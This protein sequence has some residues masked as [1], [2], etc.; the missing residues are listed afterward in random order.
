MG[1]GTETFL[2]DWFAVANYSLMK[3][4]HAYWWQAWAGFCLLGAMIGMSPLKF[5]HEQNFRQII[6]VVIRKAILYLSFLLLSLPLISLYL[7][8]A[9]TQNQLA[10]SQ[11]TFIKW[12]IALAKDNWLDPVAGLAVGFAFRFTF[13]RYVN[14]YISNLMRKLRNEVVEDKLSD[15]RSEAD[16]YKAKDFDPQKHYKPDQVFV[17]LDAESKPIYIPLSTWLETNAQVIGPTRYGKGVLLGNLIDQSIRRG[18]TVFYLDPKEDKFLPK[19]MQ[20]ACED[21]GRKFYYLTLH[22]D[23]IG[24]WAPF[25]GGTERD[26]LA[27]VEA[28]F[29]L[30]LTGDP[31]TDFY[32]S[33]ERKLLE[34]FFKKSRNI[35]GLRNLMEN[36]DALRINAELERWSQITSLCPNSGGGFSIEKALTENAVV[37]V[38]GS[39][40]DSV[41]KSATKIFILELLQEIKRL[42]NSRTA[43]VTAAIDE[44]SFLVFKELAQALATLVGFRSN[45]V[46]AYQS[47]NDLL[48]LEDQTVN[49]KY[50]YQSINVNSQ[51]KMVYGGADADTAEWASTLSGTIQKE[52]TKMEKTDVTG[53]GGEAW[54]NQRTVGATEENYIT[55]N[56]VLTLP[57][58]VC[59]IVQPRKLASL[60]Y[61]SFIPVK[62]PMALSRYIENKKQQFAASALPPPQMTPVFDNSSTVPADEIFIDVQSMAL[63]DVVVPL[64]QKQQDEVSQAK[65]VVVQNEVAETPQNQTAETTDQQSKNR[66]RKQRQKEKAKLGKQAGDLKQNET[67]TAETPALSNSA[68]PTLTAEKLPD[69]LPDDLPD[70]SPGIIS[71]ELPD[72]AP[73]V[74]FEA[75][76]TKTQDLPNSAPIKIRS[77]KDSMALLNSDNDEE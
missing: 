49:S 14:P 70:V 59:I 18:D 15:I 12:F 67:A 20:Q 39:L 29:G 36:T 71:Q 56:T 73:D 7:Y 13:Q 26:G 61:T 1:N 74:I 48:A 43:H 41:I 25:A 50:I 60:L 53:V 24:K 32:K 52:V 40:T 3:M 37:Y 30:Q 11:Q 44:V 68:V 33:Q 77:D 9:T 10:Q 6:F 55:M 5:H 69:E 28:A 22:D 2:L 38:Q 72:H 8:D 62:D 31:G 54:D 76:L 42:H 27:R 17:G 65:P 35:E 4:M 66:A 47:Q 46:L 57:P 23:G 16:K 19:I 64:T 21:T 34:T 75:D 58:R 51:I 45:F 63:P